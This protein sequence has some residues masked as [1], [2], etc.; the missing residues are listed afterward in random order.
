MRIVFSMYSR[1]EA[2]NRPSSTVSSQIFAWYPSPT[3]ALPVAPED[4]TF[5]QIVGVDFE[6]ETEHRNLPL[7]K[8]Q[9]HQS[10]AAVLIVARQDRF[11][12]R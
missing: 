9:D 8:T 4:L 7:T 3:I 2:S 10:T 1:L 6:A 11:Q 5:P 12:K